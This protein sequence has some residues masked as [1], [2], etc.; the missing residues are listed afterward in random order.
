MYIHIPF[1]DRMC[2]FCGCHTKQVNRYDPI[3][4]YLHDN[5]VTRNIWVWLALGL[6]L[7]LMIAAVYLPVLSD[8]LRLS[9]PGVSGWWVILACSLVPLFVAPVV[10]QVATACAAD[11]L[12]V[13]RTE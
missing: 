3:P 5:E 9:D 2:W 11:D 7:L 10:R 8:V 12:K 13:R 4:P 1:C 6:C